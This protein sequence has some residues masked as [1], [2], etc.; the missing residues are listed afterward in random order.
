MA[1]LDAALLD[2]A[3]E[4]VRDRLSSGAVLVATEEERILGTV[5]LDDTH[6]EAI[7]VRPNRRGQ[8]IGTALVDAASTRGRLTAAFRPGVSEFYESLGFDIER[9]GDRWRGVKPAAR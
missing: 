6:I 4:T 3:V 8:G 5:V 1:I 2:I 7:A 9:T